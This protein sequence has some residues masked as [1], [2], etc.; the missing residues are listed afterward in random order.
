[1]SINKINNKEKEKEKEI[2][3]NN[4]STD[5]SNN[6]LED[7]EIEKAIYFLLSDELKNKKINEKIKFLENKIEK[8]SLSKAI[9]VLPIVNRIIDSEKE[10]I[11]QIN[12]AN[13][14]DSFEYL[15]ELGLYSTLIIT[16]L[17]INYLLDISRN[18]K[19]DIMMT[20]VEARI[21]KEILLTKDK[22]VDET[23]SEMRK[24]LQKDE[25]KEN[26][27]KIYDE[28]RR[29]FTIN[30]T[31]N[32]S[33]LI[34]QIEEDLKKNQLKVN[35]LM[36]KVESNKLILSNEIKDQCNLNFDLLSKNISFQINSLIK[37][38]F[39]K[40]KIHNEIV[41]IK[42][43]DDNNK[44]LSA[45]SINNNQV[46]DVDNNLNRATQNSQYK[47]KTDFPNEE[48][49]KLK[50]YDLLDRIRILSNEDDF[51]S[52]KNILSIQIKS[53]IENKDGNNIIN[54][55]NTHYKKLKCDENI[56]NLL[57]DMGFEQSNTSK[58]I[59]QIKDF[60]IFQNKVDELSKY[61]TDNN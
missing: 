17:G 50:L 34:K 57:I 46:I 37:N 20:E 38:E 30:T 13:N 6:D 4:Q 58:T 19:Y 15:K 28:T 1:M 56:V 18:K 52:F 27:M 23:K 43:D 25:F 33:I 14:K 54:I 40:L 59:Y 10:K 21:T 7:I 8:E 22:I 49:N 45:M 39:E 16:T 42:L 5:K 47:E 32:K 35:E 9:K 53:F 44:D 31:Q 29:S 41:N 26:F 2:E 51:L 3:N 55:N 24:Y 61:L 12:K 60:D 11:I 48:S 36:N